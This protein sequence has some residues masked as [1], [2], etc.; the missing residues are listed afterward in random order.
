MKSALI[1][2]NGYYDQRYPE[3]YK[4][5]I[6]WGLENDHS[7]ICADAGIKFFRNVNRTYGTQFF[8]NV[9]VG[10]LDSL[11]DIQ[12]TKIIDRVQAAGTHVVREWVGQVDKDYTDGQLAV[13]YAIEEC[14]CG[15]II[16][17]GGLPHPHG[18]ETDHFL[19][20]LKLMR[21]GFGVFSKK[22]VRLIGSAPNRSS[23]QGENEQKGESVSRF[24]YRAEMRD[25]FQTIHFVVSDVTIERKNA[26]LQCVSLVAAHP[27]VI[28]EGSENL[29]WNLAELRVD[30]DMDAD[31]PNTLRNEFVPG[32]D[33]GTIR[34]AKGSDPVYVIHNWYG[35]DSSKVRDTY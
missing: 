21:F 27:H 23:E 5:E 13:A 20:N 10:D 33:R 25:P 8:P 12:A 15:R 18:Y 4:R 14:R 11:E 2:L 6:E 9:L 1:F 17:Y 28:V 19:G 30:A 24:A 34:L 32:A 16:I 7:L 26:G 3:F 29:R 22:L 35:N 31:L